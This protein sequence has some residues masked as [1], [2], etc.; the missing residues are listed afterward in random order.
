M[1]TLHYKGSTSTS[2]SPYLASP[3][4]KETHTW[5]DKGVLVVAIVSCAVA[6]GIANRPR[7]VEKLGLEQLKKG[8]FED[9]S[10]TLKTSIGTHGPSCESYLGLA[11]A[12]NRTS[13]Y[14]EGLQYADQAL[15]HFPTEPSVWAERAVSNLGLRDYQAALVDAEEALVYDNNNVRAMNIRNRAQTMLASGGASTVDS[16][17]EIGIDDK[18]KGAGTLE[19]SNGHVH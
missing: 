9:A 1:K 10:A 16:D 15:R 11:K 8:R 14:K 19:A 18:A 12:C 2:S 5:F 6:I 3:S 4:Q 13:N 17:S 7:P